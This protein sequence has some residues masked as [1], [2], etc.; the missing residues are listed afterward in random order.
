MKKLF[1]GLTSYKK[2]SFV[3][4]GLTINEVVPTYAILCR[5]VE[6]Q[7]YIIVTSLVIMTRNNR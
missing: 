6:M 5:G 2:V 1:N 3:I 4:N 7:G